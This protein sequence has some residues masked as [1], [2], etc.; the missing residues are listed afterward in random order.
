MKPTRSLR[1]SVYLLV[2]SLKSRAQVAKRQ[3]VLDVAQANKMQKTLHHL[4]LFDTG[5]LQTDD[6]LPLCYHMAYFTPQLAEHEL[7]ADGSDTTF[8]PGTPFT[9][10]MW[11]GGHLTWDHDNPLRLGQTIEEITSLDRVE[12]KQTREKKSMIVITG[13]KE[14]RNENG[15]ALTD[16][17]S[18]LFREPQVANPEQEPSAAPSRTSREGTRF[19]TVKASEITLFRYSALTFNSHKIQYVSAHVLQALVEV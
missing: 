6:S 2:E 3:Q 1:N 16:L 14:Y 7:G 8:S 4:G 19:A 9:R 15:L 17:R 13:R 5:P 11:A 10:R 12:S 18:W